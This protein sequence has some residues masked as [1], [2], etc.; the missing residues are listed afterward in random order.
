MV[1]VAKGR[2]RALVLGA[3]VA[4]HWVLDYISH[5]PDVPLYPGGEPLGLGLWRSRVGSLVVE[6]GMFL[7]GIAIYARTTRANDGTGSRGLVIFAALVA[8]MGAS[9]FY[10]PP[11]PSVLPMAGSTSSSWCRSSSPTGSMATGPSSPP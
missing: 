8:I 11:P 5:L 4:S 1:A 7:G 2:R 6:V 10:S 9:A 3:L